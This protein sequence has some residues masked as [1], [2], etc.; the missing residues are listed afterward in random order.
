MNRLG[1]LLLILC[2]PSLS[3]VAQTK[4]KAPAKKVAAP[5]KETPIKVESQ[6][7][8]EIHWLTIDELQTKMAANPKK[9]FIDVYTDW[10]G[11][12]KKMDA[13]TFSNPELIAYMNDNFYCV[14]FNAERRD[15]FRFM[16]KEYY[17]DPA[18]RAN[19]LAFELMGGK[20]SYPTSIIME[21]R[22]TNPQPVPGYHDVKEME[23]IIRYFGDNIYKSQ[24]WPDY[25][26]AFTPKWKSTN[27]GPVTPPA[28]H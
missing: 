11:W 23:M 16:G 6:A 3:L 17:F 9:V 27:E 20:L 12:C 24:Q 2:L 13:S 21:E 4:K 8:A 5:K 25:Q 14:K 15:T 10:C 1:F 26:K 18:K 7:E 28:G 22:Y 19:T